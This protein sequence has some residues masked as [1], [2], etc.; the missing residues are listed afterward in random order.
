M[1]TSIEDTIMDGLKFMDKVFNI[2]SVAIIMYRLIFL[3][4]A[5]G[6]DFWRLSFLS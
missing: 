1:E 2:S 5:I 6:A 3:V 4:F